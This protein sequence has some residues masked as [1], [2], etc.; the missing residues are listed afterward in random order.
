MYKLKTNF[1]LNLSLRWKVNGRYVNCVGTTIQRSCSC[2][3][4]KPERT[5]V[6]PAA[7]QED[8]AQAFKDGC[9]FIEKVDESTKQDISNTPIDNMVEGTL[10][11]KNKINPHEHC[12]NV[13]QKILTTIQRWSVVFPIKGAQLF[14]W[15]NDRNLLSLK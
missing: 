6:L 2:Y 1:H 9:H 4:I 3:H 10:R 12:S 15:T 7:T 8:L 13:V 5:Y 14:N 11:L